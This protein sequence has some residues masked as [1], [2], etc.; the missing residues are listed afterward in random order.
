MGMQFTMTLEGSLDVA[1][2]LKEL[3]DQAEPALRAALY[4][5]GNALLND[6]K[7]VCP[8]DT[9]RLITSGYVKPATAQDLEV[10]VGYGGAAAPY[11]LTVHENPRSGKTGG[12]SPSGRAYKHWASVGEWKYLERPFIARVF[13]YYDRIAQS[14]R[15]SLLK[16]G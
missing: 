9:T 13:G 12:V 6:S 15:R 8:V 2:A 11:A 1:K 10:V 4:E 3:G 7:A 16:G 14:L 5:E